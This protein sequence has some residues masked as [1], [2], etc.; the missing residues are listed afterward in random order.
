MKKLK[1]WLRSVLLIVMGLSWIPV[2][3]ADLSDGLVAI[4]LMEMLRM[5]MGIME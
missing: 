4:R 3:W 1:C 2:V 5:R